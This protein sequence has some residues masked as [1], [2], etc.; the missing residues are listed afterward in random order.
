MV[1]GCIGDEKAVAPVL[2]F[3]RTKGIGKRKKARE[4]ELEWEQK[5]NQEGENLLG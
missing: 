3:L 4:K 2:K 1:N 5:N